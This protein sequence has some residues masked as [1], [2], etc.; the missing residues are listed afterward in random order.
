MG[1]PKDGSDVI[2]GS[3]NRI[4]F[5]MDATNHWKGFSRLGLG[6]FFCLRRFENQKQQ[7]IPLETQ[8]KTTLKLCGDKGRWNLNQMSK[9]H[10][11]PLKNLKNGICVFQLP[12]GQ[13]PLPTRGKLGQ[14]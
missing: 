9:K 4:D 6:F 11:T 7:P 3:G 2:S 5:A 12:L 10:L 1:R 8:K 14:F 13:A